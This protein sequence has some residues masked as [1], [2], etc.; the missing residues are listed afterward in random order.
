M[1]SKNKI[2]IFK[3]IRYMIKA[4]KNEFIV[5]GIQQTNT[6]VANV[7]EIL[8]KLEGALINEFTK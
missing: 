7:Y 5:D 8:D 1:N 3:N 2:K 6:T 4:T